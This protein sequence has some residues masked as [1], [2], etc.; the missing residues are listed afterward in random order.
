VVVFAN[1]SQ[2]NPERIAHGVAAIYK[3]ELAPQS[4][5]SN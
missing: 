4:R 2:A 1:L 5:V 3:P